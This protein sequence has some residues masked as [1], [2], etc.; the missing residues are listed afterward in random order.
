MPSCKATLS[1]CYTP[2]ISNNPNSSSRRRKLVCPTSRPS[3][4]GKSNETRNAK[5][6][7]RLCLDRSILSSSTG[8]SLVELGHTKVICSVHG[9]R[10][11]T[12]SSLTSGPGGGGELHSSGVL[13][14]ELRYAPTFGIRP[15]T[16]VLTTA[17]NLDGYSAGAGGSGSGL[18][19]Q[20]VELSLRLHDAISPAVPLEFLM[21]NVVDVFVMVLQDDGSVFSASAIAASLALS[22]AG[23]EIYDLVSACSVAVIPRSIV[24]GTSVNDDDDQE[25]GEYQLL[26]DPS[27][28]EI[29]ASDGIVTLSMMGNW[30]EVTFWDQTGRLDPKVANDAAALCRDGCL[31]MTKFMRKRLLGE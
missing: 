24:V 17:T 8:S 22:D 28:D 21:K 3:G 20:E 19:A 16:K 23:V 18:S 14:C 26:A 30:K 27:E 9:P 1:N 10:S 5:T 31:T 25:V 4:S 6:I 13:N 7:R 29:L 11:L 12:S 2:S 15:E